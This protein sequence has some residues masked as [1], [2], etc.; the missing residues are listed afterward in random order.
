MKISYTLVSLLLSVATLNGN[1]QQEVP[2][3]FKKGSVVLADG[4]TMNGFI[5]ENIRSSASVTFLSADGKKKEYNSSQ[6]ASV[7]FD[8]TKYLL[9]GGDFFKILS[10]GHMMFLQKSS[11]VS[12][13][14]LYNGTEPYL[15]TGTKGKVGDYFLFKAGTKELKLI[16]K[17]NFEELI[18]S[19]FENNTAAID[20]AKLVKEDFA[21]L[22][23]AVDIYNKQ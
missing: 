8:E 3:R 16:T 4:S 22:K 11:D 20:K 7:Q 15:A 23:E 10:D 21:Q 9:V 13:K 18:A 6:L 5:K 17:K 1:A 14:I 12:G 2:N 19:S